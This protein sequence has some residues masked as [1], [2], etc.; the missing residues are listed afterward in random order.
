M[1]K[2]TKNFWGSYDF[3]CSNSSVHWKKKSM[4]PYCQPD[5]QFLKYIWMETITMEVFKLRLLSPEWQ[6][7]SNRQKRRTMDIYVARKK[8]EVEI[9][10]H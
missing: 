1:G 7:Q 4:P 9:H 3:C 6:V 2:K 10:V 5:V 8:R